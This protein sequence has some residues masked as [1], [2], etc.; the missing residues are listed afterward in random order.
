MELAE[1]ED[2]AMLEC[3][4]KLDAEGFYASVA[5]DG[6][7]RHVCGLTS[8]YVLLQSQAL[9]AGRLLRYEQAVTRE[10]QSM[11]SFGAMAFG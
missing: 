1:R 10:T 5:K 4:E 6:D 11:V 7:R 2:R 9:T 8:V 3:A